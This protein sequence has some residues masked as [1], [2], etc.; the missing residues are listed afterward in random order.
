[1]VWTVSGRLQNGSNRIMVLDFLRIGQHVGFKY[2]R[3]DGLKRKDTFQEMV[4]NV[5]K[6]FE[7]FI[8]RTTVFSDRT[9]CGLSI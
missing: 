8:Y 5:K 1:M 4:S 7:M 3:R 9:A 2:S 6:W